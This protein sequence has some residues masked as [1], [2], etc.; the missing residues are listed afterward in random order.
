[1]RNK[2]Q[3]CTGKVDDQGSCHEITS[4]KIGSGNGLILRR[5]LTTLR[6]DQGRS[7]DIIT[8]PLWMKEGKISAK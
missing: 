7:P 3:P 8:G 6:R 2:L 5:I 1:M 4:L